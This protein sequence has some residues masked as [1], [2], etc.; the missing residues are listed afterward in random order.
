MRQIPEQEIAAIGGT[1][2]FPVAMLQLCE[3]SY[4]ASGIKNAV[5]NL[6]PYTPS[7][8]WSCPWGPATNYPVDS[9]LAFVA[10]YYEQNT[11]YPRYTCLVIRGTDLSWE[12]LI[13]SLWQLWQDFDPSNMVPVPWTSTVPGAA[14][15][16]G[17]YDGLGDVL[18]LVSKG[19]QLKDWIPLFL[20]EPGNSN[21]TLIVTGHSLGGCLTSVV[22]PW[23][24]ANLTSTSVPIVPVTFA[25]PTAGNPQFVTDFETRF[26]ISLCYQNPLDIAPLFFDNLPGVS[27]IYLPL[28][29]NCP[30]DVQFVLDYFEYET[31]GLTYQ[32]T[33]S[34]PKLPEKPYGTTIWTDE[35]AYQ[36]HATT[37]MD[38]LGGK[39]VGRAPRMTRR[40]GLRAP[41]R[42]IG[43]A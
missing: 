38:L 42:H 15:A 7:G 16:G 27:N 6:P 12:D 3:I 23:F 21:T 37:Y 26:R 29:L 32:Q 4:L 22:A 19:Y 24:D 13:G 36:H 28:F 41:A 34:A 18:T 1:N 17:T 43:L 11:A 33:P 14:I 2:A 25:A 31:E 40:R 20:G 35:A 10:C 8:S 30:L 9:N 5:E 39:N